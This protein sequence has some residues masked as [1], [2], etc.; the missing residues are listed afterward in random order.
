MYLRSAATG[1][2]L[3]C[4]FS[5]SFDANVAA[6]ARDKIELRTP[7]GSTLETESRGIEHFK[8]LV[9]RKPVNIA[10]VLP[11]SVNFEDLEKGHGNLAVRK[12]L[13][14]GVRCSKDLIGEAVTAC[15]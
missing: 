7:G 3:N 10:C 12:P 9:R 6:R 14:R 11:K 13:T 2:V 5:K 4:D 15:L 1:I 8:P